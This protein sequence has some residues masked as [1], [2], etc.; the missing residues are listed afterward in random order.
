MYLVLCNAALDSG[1]R[2]EVRI[3]GGCVDFNFVNAELLES[4]TG[5]LRHA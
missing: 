1:K 4:Q 2:T 5:K 3:Q